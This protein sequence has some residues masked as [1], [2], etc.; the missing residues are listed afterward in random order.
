MKQLLPLLLLTTT[1]LLA[2]VAPPPPPDAARPLQ[3]RPRATPAARSNMLARSGGMLQIPATGPAIRFIN[4]QQEV[5]DATIAATTAQIG[6]MFRL[7]LVN[8]AA[9]GA[10]PAKLAR[11]AL[12]QPDTAAAIVICATPGE[13]LLLLAPEARWAVV[14]VSALSD[15]DATLTG[16]RLGKELWRAFGY[17]LG[18]AHSA[19]PHCLLKPVQQAADLDKLQL[20]SLSPEPYGKIIDYAKSLGI[21]PG[22]MTTYRRA[23]MEGWAP[24]PTNEV[25]KAVWQ[26]VKEKASEK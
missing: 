22:S 9:S 25:Q 11:Q 3:R 17:L 14:N 8:E 20:H 6:Q 13:P 10:E 7:P 24:A 4:A 16:Q 2:Q 1:T 19:T 5:N 12:A 26:A 18:A 15:A 21:T 23:V